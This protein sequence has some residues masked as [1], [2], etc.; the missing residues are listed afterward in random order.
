MKVVTGIVVD[1]KVAVPPEIEEGAQVAILA[2]GTDR[3]FTL[4][5]SE[6]EELS[7]ALEDIHGGKFVDGWALLQEIQ[8][9]RRG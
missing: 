8:A 6:E 2:P 7:Q 9:K 4:S 3:P 5:R 1:G